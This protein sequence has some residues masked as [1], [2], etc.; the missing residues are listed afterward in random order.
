MAFFSQIGKVY[1][2]NWDFS[3]NWERFRSAGMFFQPIGSLLYIH[4]RENIW[5]R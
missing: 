1:F 4:Y 3:T 2:L 5:Y